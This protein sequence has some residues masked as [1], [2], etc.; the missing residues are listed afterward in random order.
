ML[1][2]QERENEPL[3]RRL[4]VQPATRSARSFAHPLLTAS[5]ELEAARSV[6]DGKRPRPPTNPR[7]G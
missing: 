1:D 2:D 3:A 6:R 4:R 5:Y 7:P